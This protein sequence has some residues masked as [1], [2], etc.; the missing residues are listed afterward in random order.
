MILKQRALSICFG[1]LS[2]SNE[3]ARNPLSELYTD[4]GNYRHSRRE[5]MQ[6]Q[7][8][9][10]WREQITKAMNQPRSFV[11]KMPMIDLVEKIHVIIS[12]WHKLKIFVQILYVSMVKPF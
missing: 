7:Q 8:F 4:I 3:I 1:R 12:S 6:L 5:L 2:K 11:L 10:I 9:S